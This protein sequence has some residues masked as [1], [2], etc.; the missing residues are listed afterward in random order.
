MTMAMTTA[1]PA[2]VP[3]AMTEAKTQALFA[4]VAKSLAE[5]RVAVQGE[6]GRDVA[7]LGSAPGDIPE[8]IRHTLRG[9]ADALRWL[10]RAA[11]E[12]RSHVIA[13]DALLALLQTGGD[14]VGAFPEGIGAGGIDELLHLSPQ[15]FDAVDGA[16]AAARDG[17]ESFIG[18]AQSILPPVEDLDALRR[19]IVSLL[20]E[21]HGPQTP[22][23]GALGALML[24]IGLDT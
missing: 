21:R 11:D 6:P 20:G 7:A 23:A 19:E 5:F 18:L 16:I 17:V 9:V 12:V 8:L 4:I 14:A 13:A 15:V 22:G 1:T 24:S 10:H 2:A 3:A